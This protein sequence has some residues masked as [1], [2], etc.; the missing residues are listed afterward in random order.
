[1][2]DTNL[3][4]PPAPQERIT[5][6]VI[7]HG[8]WVR[9]R[10]AGAPLGALF[11]AFGL[12]NVGLTLLTMAGGVDIAHE[13]LDPVGMAYQFASALVGGLGNA[14]ALRLFVMG[15]ARLF[16]V[17]AKLLTCAT[18]LGLFEFASILVPGALAP[19]GRES[20]GVAELLAALFAYLF[21]LYVAFRL[22]LW[23]IG[24]LTGVDEL[25]PQTS[26]RLMHKAVGGLILASISVV[27]PASLI[28]GAA[29][30]AAKVDETSPPVQML[31][32]FFGT[33]LAIVGAA[34]AATVYTLRVSRHPVADVFD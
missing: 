11:V 32:A 25:T 3:R 34:F 2:T 18:M 4:V 31:D 30:M 27:L 17:D 14:F 20:G 12:C 7:L 28:F 13:G 29:A 16:E 9:I 24:R 8:G 15:P 5:T 19:H 6:K 26:W 33:G 21:V 10:E 1:M 23:P 22:T